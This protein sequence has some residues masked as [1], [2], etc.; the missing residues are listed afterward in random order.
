MRV[1]VTGGSGFIGSHLIPELKAAGHIVY[2]FDISSGWVH[3]LRNPEAPR[4]IASLKPDAVI[5]LAAKVGRLFGEDD[6]QETIVDNAGMTAAVA[7]VCGEHNIRLLYASTSE[8]YGDW[9]TQLCFEDD[10]FTR[11]PHN[12]YGLSKRWGEEACRLYAP[13]GLT[14]MRFSMPYGPGLPAGRGR[15]ALINFLYSALHL[16]RLTVH[17]GSER[18]WCWI[19]DTVRAVRLLLELTQGGAYNIGRDDNNTT[20]REVAE[21]ACDLTGAPHDLIQEVDPPAMQTVVKRL[22]MEKIRD[23]GWEPRVELDE[24]M[25]R[26]LEY[27]KKTYPLPMAA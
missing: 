2:N 11:V 12:M 19:G 27:V 22:S 8:V 24:G 9:D 25:E 15:A 17:R 14:I 3:N 4:R 5:H 23:L 26:C 21:M 20:M 1:V 7:Q 6:V 16:E 13:E 10:P 18:S